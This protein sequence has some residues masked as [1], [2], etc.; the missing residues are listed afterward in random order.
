MKYYYDFITKY[1]SD[2]VGGFPGIKSA[3]VARFA[4][5]K[6]LRYI[7]N[8]EISKTREVAIISRYSTSL[9]M[10]TNIINRKQFGGRLT[11]TACKLLTYITI[12]YQQEL[13]PRKMV[14]VLLEYFAANGLLKECR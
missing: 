5:K 7:I 1:A 13:L 10:R 4:N 9:T 11:D 8:I 2:V 12:H 6:I 14:D 3:H